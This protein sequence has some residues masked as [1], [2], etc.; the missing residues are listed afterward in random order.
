MY[1]SAT[2]SRERMG[3]R[4]ENNLTNRRARGL[5]AARLHHAQGITMKHHDDAPISCGQPP[6]GV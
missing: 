5:V 2:M 1:Q 4:L 3:K 6:R